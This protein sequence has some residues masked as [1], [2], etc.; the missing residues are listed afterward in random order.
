MSLLVLKA[1]FVWLIIAVLAVFNAV[2]REK[3]LAPLI[4][5]HA[6][7]PVSGLMLSALILLAAF[8]SVP[9]FEAA[10]AGSYLFVGFL[11]LVFTLLFEFLFGRFAAG[12]TWHEIIQVFNVKKG[13]LFMLV[14]LS[15]F[16][17]PWLSA[18]LR[19]I[20]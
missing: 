16:I 18:E 1:A 8:L 11:W 6:A 19:L 15:A 5:P 2:F 13:D 7:L 12:K 14:L 9:F 10:K 17:S 3:L 20:V 4:G